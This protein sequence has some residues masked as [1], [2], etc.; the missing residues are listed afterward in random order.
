MEYPDFTNMSVWKKSIDLLLKIY[1]ITK[2]F[3]SDERFGLIS[4]MRRAVN[5][6]SHNFSEGFG[7][8]EPRDKTRFYK[9]SRGSGYEPMSQSFASFKLGYIREKNALDEII[10][11]TTKIV[12]ELT[13]LKFH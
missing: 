3:P 11:D 12:N 1:V 9:I 4:D 10:T 8:F 6:I 2:S 5:S 7:R 13:A